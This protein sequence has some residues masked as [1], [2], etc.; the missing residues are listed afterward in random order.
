MSTSWVLPLVAGLTV[1]LTLTPI[2]RHDAWWIRGF[3]FPRVQ[4]TVLTA[5]VLALYGG[6][7]G[8]ET[9]IDLAAVLALAACVVVQLYQIAPYTPIWR[10]QILDADD[11]GAEISSASSSRTS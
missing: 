6:M 11:S 8:M 5:G 10:R 2:V 7:R 3:E 9:A 4:T 1:L